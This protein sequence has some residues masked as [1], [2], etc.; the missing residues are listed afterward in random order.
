MHFRVEQ[1]KITSAVGFFAVFWSV[2]NPD[3]LEFFPFFRKILQFLMS[4]HYIFVLIFHYFSLKIAIFSN[5][6]ACTYVLYRYKWHY[7]YNNV[8]IFSYIDAIW[9]FSGV[10]NKH[11]SYMESLVHRIKFNGPLLALWYVALNLELFALEPQ[12]SGLTHCRREKL[13]APINNL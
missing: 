2:K 10:L 4:L 8:A 3:F 13:I 1:Q 11:I 6:F 5:I 9:A 7:W 12:M